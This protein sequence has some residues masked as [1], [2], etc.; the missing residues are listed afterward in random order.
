M[1][2][3]VRVTLVA[4]DELTTVMSVAPVA[5][6]V[7]PAPAA[8]PTTPS[9]GPVPSLIND[10]CPPIVPASTSD[11]V[12]AEIVMSVVPV[13]VSVIPTPAAKPTTPIAGPIPSSTKDR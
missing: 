3:L 13:A 2:A 6:S 12:S 7:M 11:V 1:P 4:G 10:K 8:N 5:V 9:V